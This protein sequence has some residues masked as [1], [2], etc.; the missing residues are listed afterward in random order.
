MKKLVA[1]VG[2]AGSGKSIATDYLKS[3]GWTK[4]YFGGVIYD[5]MRA[6]GIEI[7]PTSQK[8]YRE[9]IRK[10]YGMGAVAEILK[11]DIKKAYEKGNTVLDGL[12]SWDEYL[13]LNKEF[14]DKLKLICVCCDKNIRYERIGN[15]KDRPFNREEIAF[16]DQT[17]IENAA[18]GG[19][20]AFADYYI[21]NNGDLDE[22]IDRLNEILDEIS[23]TEEGEK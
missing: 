5:R 4:I 3:Q 13:I 21:L 11:N 2:M 8:E 20:I 7:T 1:V 14:G 12:Y 9:N 6:E 23:K 22:Y 18:K 17:E 10:K 15:R 19:P 16:R